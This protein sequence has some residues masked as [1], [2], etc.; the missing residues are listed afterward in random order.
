M[1]NKT[2]C[3]TKTKDNVFVRIDVA[4]QM[5]VLADNG[6]DAIYRLSDPNM[7]VD[8]FVKDVIRGTVPGMTLDHSFEAK[9]EIATAVKEA[10]TKAMSGFG[11]AI[12]NTLVTDVV[13]DGNVRKAMNDIETSKRLKEAAETKALADKNVQIHSAEADAESKFLQGQGIARQ[14]GAII[15]GLKESLGGGDV[16]PERVSELLLITQYFDTLKEVSNGSNT[17]LF[18]PHSAAGVADVANQLRDHL[19]GGPDQQKM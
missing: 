18:I 6:Y 13:P 10:L 2:V 9:D 16:S 19:R 3:E 1:E 14:R 17:T 5:Q 7:Q 4:V 8:S 11:Y 15:D 12:L